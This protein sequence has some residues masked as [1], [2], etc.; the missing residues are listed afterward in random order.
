[1]RRCHPS[2]PVVPRCPPV[3][4]SPC[5]PAPQVEDLTKQPFVQREL[6]LIK[7]AAGG[8][9]ARH[10]VM[11]IAAIFRARVVDVSLRTMTLEVRA[12]DSSLCRALVLRVTDSK[13]V[14]PPVVRWTVLHTT[15]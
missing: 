3:P 14:P 13:V 11:D 8:G 9:P 6:M 12:V 4:L 5:P 15:L 10:E 1:M 2:L 7:V